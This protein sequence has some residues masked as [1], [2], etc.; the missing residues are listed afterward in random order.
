MALIH[1]KTYQS[2]NLESANVNDYIVTQ[3]SQIFNL[4]GTNNIKLIT[5]I[6]D[7]ELDMDIIIPLGLMINELILNTIKYAFPGDSKGHL[8]IKLKRSDEGMFLNVCDDG[9]G[10]PYDLDI[11]SS[12]SL[13]MTI[14]Q[15]LTSQIGGELIDLKPS[16]GSSIL[17]KFPLN[18]NTD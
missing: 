2:G 5:D 14:L 7:I 4:Y 3:A 8:S 1:D 6:E 10:L 13:G 9:V 16:K 12:N 18:L 15:N 17:I 11:N